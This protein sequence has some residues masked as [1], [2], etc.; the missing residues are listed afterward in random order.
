[1]SLDCSHRFHVDVFRAQRAQGWKTRWAPV[2]WTCVS[3]KFSS[4]GNKGVTSIYCSMTNLFKVECNYHSFSMK[5]GWVIWH[6]CLCFLRTSV[7]SSQ[8]HSQIWECIVY[9]CPMADKWGST[10]TEGPCLMST[11]YRV[12]DTQLSLDK[13]IRHTDAPVLHTETPEQSA[14]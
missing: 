8:A 6:A 1:M 5:S 9:V 11:P 4:T 13:A 7:P 10:Y 2:S 3:Q 12:L 14:A